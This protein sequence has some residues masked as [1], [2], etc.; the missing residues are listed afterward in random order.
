[1]TTEWLGFSCP[2]KEQSPQAQQVIGKYWW[3]S[4]CTEESFP[5]TIGQAGWNAFNQNIP[6]DHM[7]VLS[8][9]FVEDTLKSVVCIHVFLQGTL[10]QMAGSDLLI[11]GIQNKNGFGLAIYHKML[12]F[13]F[14]KFENNH[15]MLSKVFLFGCFICIQ[16]LCWNFVLGLPYFSSIL[17]FISIL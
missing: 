14:Q 16:L 12:V 8:W 10:H 4:R 3:S 11:Y 5:C 2:P 7:A 13:T 6:T 17:I 9:Y 1:M 15:L